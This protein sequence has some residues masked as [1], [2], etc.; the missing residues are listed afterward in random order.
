MTTLRIA[1]PMP[2]N[3]SVEYAKSQVEY[4]KARTSAEKLAALKK[5]LT[6]APKHKSAEKLNLQL[7]RRLAEQKKEIEREKKAG[8]GKSFAIKKE[9]AATVAFLGALDSGKSKIFSQLSG[10][11]YCGE[12]NYGV[13]MRMIH[14]EN[15]WLQA[16]DMMAFYSNFEKSTNAGHAFNLIRN[17]DVLILVANDEEQLQLLQKTLAKAKVRVSQRK[18]YEMD[19]TDLPAIVISSDAQ[20][21]EQLKKQIWLKTGKIRVQTKTGDRIAE[22]PV[23][24]KQ[25]ATVKDLAGTIHQDFLRK[26]KY[27][28]VRG[29]SAIFAGQQVGLSHKLKDKDV[30]EL[31][32]K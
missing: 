13:K 28:R 4:F 24:L 25:D 21:L 31:F 18:S 17:S 19:T 15:V 27:A 14:Y 29:P 1:N 20:D 32:L 8:K 6:T 30:V 9:G 23:I 16:L 5:M 10:A 11:N 3:V 26:F 12:N 2:T 22:K 7:K